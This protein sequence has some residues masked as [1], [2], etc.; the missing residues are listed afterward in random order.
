MQRRGIGGPAAMMLRNRILCKLRGSEE[1]TDEEDR[2]RE[3]CAEG[4]AVA[5]RRGG[6][7]RA[8]VR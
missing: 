2:L 7:A 8:E 5:P 4:P 3:N 6:K 1:Q